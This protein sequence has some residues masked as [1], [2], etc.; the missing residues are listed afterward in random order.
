M[1]PDE[2]HALREEYEKRADDW[3]MK[4][5]PLG[6]YSPFVAGFAGLGIVF[7]SQTIFYIAAGLSNEAFDQ[8]RTLALLSG[9]LVPFVFIKYENHRYEKARYETMKDYYAAISKADAA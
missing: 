3:A 9:F 6:K 8:A 2:R 1:T 5:V 4:R 7:L